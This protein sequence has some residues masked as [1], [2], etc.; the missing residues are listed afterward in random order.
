MSRR[1]GDTSQC[2]QRAGSETPK[3]QRSTELQ[4]LACGVLRAFDLASQPLGNGHDRAS[5]FACHVAGVTCTFSCLVWGSVIAGQPGSP[6]DLGICAA[7]ANTY[8]CHCLLLLLLLNCASATTNNMCST[9]AALSRAFHT[10][11]RRDGSSLPP[12]TPP[13]PP[14]TGRAETQKS[15][16]TVPL[17]PLT[18][19]HLGKEAS[20]M[21][22]ASAQAALVQVAIKAI[23]LADPDA[24]DHMTQE[25][26]GR[27]LV[28]LMTAVEKV[29]T[30]RGH[31]P[32]LTT[33]GRSD[34]DTDDNDWV[35]PLPEPD[36][37][38]E[39][40]DKG[41]P[42]VKVKEEDKEKEEEKEAKAPV[43][44]ADVQDPA[45]PVVAAKPA[46]ALY[47]THMIKYNYDWRPVHTSP[48]NRQY[49]LAE[50]SGTKLFLDR[51]RMAS[52]LR[53]CK[54]VAP[55]PPAADILA[56]RAIPS[57]TYLLKSG[58][59]HAVFIGPRGGRFV[60]V[61]G[62]KKWVRKGEPVRLLVTE[63][64]QAALGAAAEE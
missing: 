56:L 52:A 44:L 7:A 2:K 20:N 49:V 4:Q 1:R 22:A 29:V 24:W 31:S 57:G 26:E 62:A 28:D 16:V 13:L 47:P 12:P 40:K 54:P 32:S 5:S 48:S 3:P 8:L 50:V 15:S 27:R 23:K 41:K 21:D 38:P 10:V 63:H 14:P 19:P 6:L 30:A 25:E 59:F 58:V 61:G 11:R 51:P 39:V 60:I 46:P 53:T 55:L 64:D 36:D 35:D 9:W 45:A 33:V 17:A 34:E 37:D 43:T 42:E 18:T